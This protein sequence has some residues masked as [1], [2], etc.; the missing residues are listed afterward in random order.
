MR[1]THSRPDR[2]DL[3]RPERVPVIN[4]RDSDFCRG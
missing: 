1:N 3:Y 2:S 4:V